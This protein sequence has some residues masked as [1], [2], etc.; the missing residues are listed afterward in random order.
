MPQSIMNTKHPDY[1]N[2]IDEVLKVRDCIEGSNAIKN[3][4]PTRALAYLPHPSDESKPLGGE[5]LTGYNNRYTAY[6]SRAEF[7]EF[8]AQT[9]RG[10]LGSMNSTPPEFEEIPS[11]VDYLIMNSD[12]DGL[13][14]AESIEITQANL[15]EVKFHG[16][17]ADF[18]GLTNTDSSGNPAEQAAEP[19]ATIK[20][21]PRESIV[22]W[23]YSSVNGVTKLTYVKLSETEM[24]IEKEQFQRVTTENQLILAIDE[25]GFYYQ[26]QV[27]I[28]TDGDEIITDPLY[29]ENN[30][31]KMDFIPFEIVIDQKQSSTKLPRQLGVLYPIAL[32][33]LARYQVNADLKESLHKMGQPTTWSKGWTN[34]A[35]E[36]YKNMT[37]RSHIAVG[38]CSHIPL[39]VN[40]DIGLL[41]W[42]G[43]SSAI[44]K[45]LEENQKEAKAMG[46]RFN[47]QEMGDEAVGVA[48]IR[49]A[50][51]L[52]VLIN[53]Q[54]SIEESYARLIKW[55][56]SFMSRS[57]KDPDVVI[58]LNK[59]FNKVRITAQEQQAIANNLMQGVIDHKEALHQLER[60]GVLTTNA[61]ALLSRMM[62]GSEVSE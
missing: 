55:C 35:F 36:D 39:P 48:V 61:E 21:Y 34:Q 23:E 17:L 15:L 12:G 53:I 32:K 47:T 19:R 9:Q 18:G 3:G 33:A 58:K 40:S 37:G 44:F 59:E 26:R 14:L 45:Y 20:H 5:Q 1:T 41:E 13:T 29:P 8:T 7:E 24:V 30:A 43:D 28:N 57:N 11:D 4:D 50:E 6:K 25:D 56:N 62:F 52:S 51:E 31:G 2:T 49:S 27:T 38:S 22:D 42:N 60:G 54:S 16:L 46:A 10:Y